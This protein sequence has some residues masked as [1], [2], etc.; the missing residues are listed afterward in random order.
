MLVYLCKFCLGESA[1]QALNRAGTDFVIA[2]TE[3]TLYGFAS[4]RHGLRRSTQGQ[5]EIPADWQL[6]CGDRPGGD[7]VDAKPLTQSIPGD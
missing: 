7:P 3:P 1:I 2:A 4:Y 5:R 6:M